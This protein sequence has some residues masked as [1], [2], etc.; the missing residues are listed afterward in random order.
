MKNILTRSYGL[1]LLLLFVYTATSKA[2]NYDTFVFQ[3]HLAPVPLMKV[4]SPFLGWSIPLI[5]FAITIALALGFLNPAI[6]IKAFQASVS[7]LTVF[8]MY[9]AAMLLSGSQLPCTC[10][11]IISMM[12]W[13]QHLIFNGVL[14]VFGV[15]SI[16]YLKKKS[17]PFVKTSTNDHDKILSRA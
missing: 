5:E 16:I 14:I 6:N 2:L 8:E 10:G 12:G 3:M 4:L 7:L 15:I 13:K 9:I 11:G 1:F 17:M